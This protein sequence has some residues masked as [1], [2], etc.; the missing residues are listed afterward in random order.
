MH[1]MSSICCEC[2]RA[3]TLLNDHRCGA[4]SWQ[5]VWSFWHANKKM[6]LKKTNKGKHP[7]RTTD[8]HRQKN[9]YNTHV[10][11]QVKGALV[12]FCILQMLWVKEVYNTWYSGCTITHRSSRLIQFQLYLPY[13]T[14]ACHFKHS[15]DFWKHI[16]TS[17]ADFERLSKLEKKLFTVWLWYRCRRTKKCAHPLQVSSVYWV[18]CFWTARF[19]A[20][21]GGDAY[22]CACCT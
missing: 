8:A 22:V 15:S 19:Q 9:I 21:M 4:V 1:C 20:S 13:F 6:Q 16:F 3:A 2:I 14:Q 12:N 10:S 17:V 11:E 18:C 7:F 5:F